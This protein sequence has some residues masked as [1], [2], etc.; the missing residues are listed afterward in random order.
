MS[1]H[2]SSL[3]CTVSWNAMNILFLLMAVL[4]KCCLMAKLS[5]SSSSGIGTIIEPLYK[6]NLRNPAYP[7]VLPQNWEPRKSHLEDN[8]NSHD[9]QRQRIGE[10]APPEPRPGQD[11]ILPEIRPIV[12]KEEWEKYGDCKVMCFPHCL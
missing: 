10:V 9:E 3:Q 6:T 2:K 12:D 7:T 5:H 8:T 11:T 4:L 1:T